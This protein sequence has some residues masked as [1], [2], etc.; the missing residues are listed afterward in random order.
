MALQYTRKKR[1]NLNATVKSECQRALRTRGKFTVY[2]I[3][4][5]INNLAG[6]QVI[7]PNRV[8]LRVYYLARLNRWERVGAYYQK[9]S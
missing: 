8:R 7:D 9:G 6:S 4:E 3:A 5:G 1:L 2:E